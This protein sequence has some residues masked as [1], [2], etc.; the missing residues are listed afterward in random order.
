MNKIHK[1][2][3]KGFTL[4]EILLVI[5][6]IGILAA[7]VL[8]AINPTRQIN[9]ARQAAINSDKNTIE[10]ALQ[11]RLIDTGQY[12]VGLD[13]VQRRICSSTVTTDCVDLSGLIP[14][15]VAAIPSSTTY[16]VARGNDG[17][18][19]VNTTETAANFTCPT[20]YIRVPGNSLYQTKDFCVMKYE[21]KAVA[22]SNPTVGLIEPNTGFDTIANNTTATTSANGRAIASVASGFPIANINQTTAASYCTTA[23]ASLITN[24]E[25]MTIARNI[26]AQSSNWRNGVIGSTDASPTN[27]GLYRG[28]SDNSPANALAANTNDS[29][30][31]EGTGNANETPVSRERR[32]H[33]LSNG[34][35]I[36]DMSGNV[37]EWTSDTIQEQDKPNNSSGNLWQQWTAI[38]NFGTL[39]YDLT[40]P[41][42][43]AWNSTQNM[44]QYYAGTV[45]GTTTFA[46]LRGGAWDDTAG[47]GV[48]SLNLDV[49]PPH[50]NFNIGF[51][52]VVR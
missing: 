51:R 36:W 39:S 23:G 49:T 25:W 41:S 12:P 52:C 28:H 14:D 30:G 46:F 18:V 29:Q 3:N 2:V 32:T 43:N 17:R 42:N 50:S 48:L 35:V 45:T 22:L 33:T 9:Q 13:G 27:G 19:Y 38:S 4:L 21:A 37:W 11:Q 16:T 7:I 8:V 34:E 40:R 47:A 5:A 24:A 31:Y 15:Y 20:G 1:R 10:K 6:A 26:E 44:G